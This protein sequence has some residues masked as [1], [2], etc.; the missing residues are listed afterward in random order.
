MCMCVCAIMH[1]YIYVCIH[2]HV[3]TCLSVCVVFFKLNL[4]WV[5]TIRQKPFSL[6]L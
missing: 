2:M 5:S 6:T 4:P 3:G 1:A